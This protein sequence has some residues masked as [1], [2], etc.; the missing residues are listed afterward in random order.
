MKIFINKTYSLRKSPFEAFERLRRISISNMYTEVC[1]GWRSHMDISGFRPYNW[2]QRVAACAFRSTDACA[3]AHQSR[4]K[5]RFVSRTRNV[6]RLY[7][8]DILKIAR[9]RKMW[10]I[11]SNTPMRFC[12]AFLFRFRE[13]FRM[14]IF[15]L[16]RH[17]QGKCSTRDRMQMK[18]AKENVKKNC[19]VSHGLILMHRMQRRVAYIAR[20]HPI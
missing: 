5:L 18:T 1:S 12:V 7:S 16:K 10:E 15:F 2:V 17:A 3:F 20:F 19:I 4:P 9:C 14:C 13:S 8:G 6:F 11:T